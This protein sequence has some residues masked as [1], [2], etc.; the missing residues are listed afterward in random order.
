LNVA[1]SYLGA[2]FYRTYPQ[3]SLFWE[4]VFNLHAF[5]Q[6]ITQS[7]VFPPTGISVDPQL[8]I[9]VRWDIEKLPG[10]YG[11]VPKRLT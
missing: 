11:S 3:R 1:V 10:K 8:A 6:A 5:Y 9:A 7:G 2:I 4:L